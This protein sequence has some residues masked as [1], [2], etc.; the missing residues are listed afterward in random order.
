MPVVDEVTI[1]YGDHSNEDLLFNF[2]FVLAED[3]APTQ[4]RAMIP[5]PPGTSE[6]RVRASVLAFCGPV[7]WHPREAGAALAACRVLVADAAA[8][9]TI[10]QR[11]LSEGELPFAA[12]DVATEGH[13]E[14]LLV[15]TLQRWRVTLC[16]GDKAALHAPNLLHLAPS[17]EY[18]R[19]LHSLLS[20]Q[21][22]TYLN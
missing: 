17:R 2:G 10:V 19:Q 8:L 21:H 11:A 5:L 16:E 9:P 7:Q 13:A 20:S 12:L 15:D 22:Y 18:R 6:Q 14:L 3:A 4:A 1:S